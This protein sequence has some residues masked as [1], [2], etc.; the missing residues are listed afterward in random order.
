VPSERVLC[1][2]GARDLLRIKMT[3]SGS[4][5]KNYEM[6]II[7]LSSTAVIVVEAL[8]NN[9][10]NAST[11]DKSLLIYK[12]DSTI[13]VGSGPIRIIPKKTSTT[14]APLSPT[15][16]DWD[17]YLEAPIS[18]YQ[19]VLYENFLFRNAEF[20]NGANVFSLFVGTNAIAQ[21]KI[22]ATTITC[23]NGKKTLKIKGYSPSCP[24]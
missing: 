14:T 23:K 1:V 24:K 17:R 7:R 21:S 6:V 16:P 22:S 8:K 10:F 9:G 2:A 19:Q 12:V 4:K 20:I 3:P 15:L 13:N 11:T 18:T 5:D